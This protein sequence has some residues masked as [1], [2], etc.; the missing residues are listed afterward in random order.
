MNHINKK[1]SFVLMLGLFLICSGY[2][3][4]MAVD[5]KFGLSIFSGGGSST[6]VLFG[7]GLDIP[8]GQNLFARPELN[9]T[10][11]NSTPIEMAGIVKYEIPNLKSAVPFY[12]DGGLGFW[13]FTGGP[14]VSMDFGGG[15]IFPISGSK[16]KIPAEIRMGPLFTSGTTTFQIA[17]TSGVRFSLK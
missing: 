6:A 2:S 11:H 4:Q 15:A 10:T 9:I 5:G 7:G 1:L 8:I 17:I 3:Q 13:F 12:I 14:Y 16:L